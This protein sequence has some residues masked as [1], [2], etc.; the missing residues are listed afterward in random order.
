MNHRSRLAPIALAGALLVV[1]CGGDDEGAEGDAT[2]DVT[3]GAD[4]TTGAESVDTSPAASTDDASADSITLVAYDSFPVEDTTLNA[5][6]DAF[7]DETGIDVELLVAGDA[8]T[9][10]SKAVLTA[11]NPE[12]DVMFGVDNAFLSRIVEGEVFERYEAAGLD[13]VPDELTS[14]VPDGEATPIDYGDVCVNYDI[15]W[16]DEQGLEPPTDLAALTDPAYED[17]LVVENP[18]T[19]SPGLAFVLASVAEFGEDGWTEYWEQLRTNGVEV[20]DGWNEAYYERFTWAGGPRPL[21]VSYGSSPPAE[22]IFADPPLDEAPTAVIE[23]T[24]FRQVEFAGVLR[25]TDAPDAAR[26]LVDFMV[27]ERFQQE[28]ALNLFVYPSNADV[29]LPQEFTDFALVPEDPFTLEPS[30]IAEGREAWI[31]TWTDTVLR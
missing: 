20:V 17:L 19:S 10:V 4:G 12:G 28:L 3:S 26:Q 16:F 30:V 14:L 21:V 15:A 1:A 23:S 7:S 25:G 31:E 6:L 22:V 13:A 27:S 24:C 5:A 9:M 2:D 8:G 11:G 29:E 18:A